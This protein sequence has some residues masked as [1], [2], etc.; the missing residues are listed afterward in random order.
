[1]FRK[2]S[3]IG[4]F[5][6]AL[7]LFPQAHKA[8]HDLGHID[9]FHCQAVTEKHFHEYHAECLICDYKQ[10]VSND[11]EFIFPV[12]FVFTYNALIFPELSD[13]LIDASFYTKPSRGPP[14]I[15][16]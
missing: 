9:D 1:M 14:A 13:R 2:S 10:P 7:F 3:L 8:I 11:H 16:I 12:S 15:F 4:F 6:L 5:L